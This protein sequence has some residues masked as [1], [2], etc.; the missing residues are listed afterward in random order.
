[1][2]TVLNRIPELLTKLRR[3][4]LQPGLNVAGSVTINRRKY[5]LAAEVTGDRPAPRWLLIDRE[6]TRFP[7]QPMQ[8][9][10]ETPTV[11]TAKGKRIC[12]ACIRM[13]GFTG[14]TVSSPDDVWCVTVPCPEDIKMPPRRPTTDAT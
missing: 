8:T 10:N 5:D 3:R 4:A 6:G 9:V 13:K 1:M 7:M 12:Y 2:P 14:K 11:A